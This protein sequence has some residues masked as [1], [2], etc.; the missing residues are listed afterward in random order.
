MVIK[1]YFFKEGFVKE[2]A[3]IFSNLHKRLLVSLHDF[4][5]IFPT[6]V[7]CICLC[8]LLLGLVP[9][10]PGCWT[11]LLHRGPGDILGGTVSECIGWS[12]T[13]HSVFDP[14]N[15]KYSP[16]D[17]K[18]NNPKHKYVQ[19]PVGHAATFSWDPLNVLYL[20]AFHC[21]ISNFM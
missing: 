16:W 3:N 20:L 6:A 10:L 13:F 19:M 17:T 21:D 8:L 15:Y 1:L 9:F 5:P 7:V 14:K 4:L 12:H 2:F 18:Y 11:L